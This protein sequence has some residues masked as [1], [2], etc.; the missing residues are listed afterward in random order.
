[1]TIDLQSYRRM[2]ADEIEAIANIATPSL[3]DALAAIPRE[4]FLDS[5]PWIVR[6]EGDLL[7]GP[8]RTPDDNPRRVYHNY[9]IAIDPA[10]QLFNGAPSLMARSIDRLGLTAGDRVL[11]V[12]LGLGYYTALVAHTV[13]PSGRVVGIEIDEA[14]A[15]RARA[16]LAEMPWVDVRAGDARDAFGE[17]FDAILVNA[18]VTHA[19]ESWL[20]ALA[21]GGRLLFPL[22]ATSPQM[23][24]VGKGIQILLT[25]NH[26]GVLDAAVVNFIAIYSGIGLRDDE[27]NA[28]IG[29]ALQRSPFPR[30]TRL[31]RDVH[32]SQT[33]CWLHT[34]SWCL[35]S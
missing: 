11:H 7:S 29:E 17:A 13:G 18:G 6:G 26:A 3:V 20:V 14:L 28:R 35:C 21:D 4:R 12:G 22:T 16:N 2:F 32:D 25:K 10:R 8:R 15:S 27:L 1:M 30:L 19:Q 33:G 5:G 24:P 31:R 23:G 34:P 9:S